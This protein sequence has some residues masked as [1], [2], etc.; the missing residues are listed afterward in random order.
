[1]G[2]LELFNEIKVSGEK[3]LRR[4]VL[5]IVTA[6]VIG[7][8]IQYAFQFNKTFLWIACG[9]SFILFLL[10]R[11][12]KDVLIF[13]FF[14]II[15]LSC[16]F[17]DFIST[18]NHLYRFQNS[19]IALEG[20]V[21]SVSQV[22]DSFHRVTVKSYSIVSEGNKIF[23]KEKVLINLTGET[24]EL[25]KWIGHKVQVSGVLIMPSS[26]RNP[27]TFNYRLY[28]KTKKIHMM[29]ESSFSQFKP[30]GKYNRVTST[31]GLFKY[32]FIEKI[33]S[34]MKPEE[35]GV[36]I[37]ILFGDKSYMDSSIYE[38]FQRNGTAHILAVSGIHIGILYSALEF[39]LKKKQGMIKDSLMISF[40]I[41]YAA[42]SEFAPSVVRAVMMI[43]LFIISKR[44]YKRYDLL[45]SAGFTAFI[46]LLY[47]PYMLFNVGF[48]LSF[49]AVLSIGFIY[50]FLQRRINYKND[51]I[52]MISLLVSIQIGTAPLIAYHFNY[53]SFAAFFINIPLVLLAEIILPVGFVLLLLSTT[54]IQLFDWVAKAEG[55]LVNLMIEMNHLATMVFKDAIHVTSPSWW[56]LV[57]FY[58][59][60]FLFAYECLPASINKHKKRV[61]A[62][63]VTLLLF[64]VLFPQLTS[65]K[66]EITFVDVGQG[67]CI[68]IRTSNGK[69]ILI[70][71][72]GSA[73]GNPYDVGKKVLVPYLLKNGVNKI[74]LA[75]ITH[76]HG[77]HYKGILSVMD[78][79]K[80][81]KTALYKESFETEV[82]DRIILA[83]KKRNSDITYLKKDDRISI[84]EGIAIDVLFPK[85]GHKDQEEN[86]NSLVLLLDYEGH[87]LLLTGDIEKEGEEVLMKEHRSLESKILKVPHHGSKT[88]STAELIRVVKP[89]IAI[90]QVGKN[91]FGHPAPEVLERYQDENVKMLRTDEKGA[92]LLDIQDNGI[93]IKTMIEEDE[94][95]L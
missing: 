56:A 78:T 5:F 66:Y 70:D 47:N 89:K 82:M 1:M 29:M 36:L 6:L 38:N 60:I 37:G 2:V 55:I 46:L 71:G 69:N 93:I 18:Q 31:I 48:Q 3:G 65:S 44:V 26:N 24:K 27:N 74:D 41:L 8:S 87:K 81:S 91:N 73:E 68:H 63:G 20:V 25:Y 19:E 7:I 28:L 85:A 88:S 21:T 75:I 16:F 84:Q 52:K 94:Y 10:R 95:E 15:F 14:S 61:G 54:P 39:L 51:F 33:M 45:S 59:I 12:K 83:C 23:T 17:F 58:L 42:V 53:F 62:V 49:A 9:L 64:L 43:V 76:L 57:L 77:D 30:I 86:N 90:I 4:S 72:G 67:D 32:R 80:V 22:N 11:A 35:A 79:I 34:A 50:P 13:L 92:I 40:L